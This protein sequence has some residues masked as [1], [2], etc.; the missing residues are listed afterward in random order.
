[1][2]VACLSFTKLGSSLGESLLNLDNKDYSFYH[3]ANSDSQGGIKD[4]FF[5]EMRNIFNVSPS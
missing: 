1:M 2:K 4:I 5:G 3:F